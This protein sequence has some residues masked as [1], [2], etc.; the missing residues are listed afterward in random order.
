[1]TIFI[2]FAPYPYAIISRKTKLGSLCL[3][4]SAF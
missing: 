1:M 3:C 4:N 2:L